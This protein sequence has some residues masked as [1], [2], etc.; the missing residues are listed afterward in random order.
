M[1]PSIEIIPVC[2]NGQSAMKLR[3]GVIGLG[4]V[5]QQRHAPALRMLADRFEVRAVC[6]QVA[7]RAQQA[8]AEFN[9]AAVDGYHALAHRED[10][11]AVL[12]LSLQWYGALPILAAC[13]SGKAVYCAAGMDLELAE[14]ETVKQ[15]VEEAGIAF[16]AEFPR[17]HAPATL[18]LKELIATRLGDPRLLFCHQRS[19]ADTPGRR[20]STAAS[21]RRRPGTWSNW[22]IGAATWSIARPAGSS[23]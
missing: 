12:I 17:R 10:L 23:A 7:H 8:A 11:D 15:R 1:L 5:W 18:R 22:S 3:V 9:A 20:R 13:D 16:M 2:V 14:A 21:G 6:D 19:V 4:E